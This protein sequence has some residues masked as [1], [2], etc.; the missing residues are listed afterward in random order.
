MLSF[1]NEKKITFNNFMLSFINKKKIIYLSSDKLNSFF[2]FNA[3]LHK[4][5]VERGMHL[6]SCLKLQMLVNMGH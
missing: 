5:R 1:I 4:K 6:I 2:F 3:A